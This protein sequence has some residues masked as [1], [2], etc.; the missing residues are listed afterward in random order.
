MAHPDTYVNKVVIG[1]EG[2]ELALV[3]FVTSALIY[4]FKGYGSAVRSLASSPAL[5][6][7]GIALADGRAAI[8][9]LR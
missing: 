1:S 7:V 6:V 9:N 8:H 4:T 3:N 5:D 2:G